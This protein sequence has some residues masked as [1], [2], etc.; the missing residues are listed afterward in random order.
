[1][2]RTVGTGMTVSLL[3]KSESLTTVNESFC[4]VN[5]NIRDRR[6]SRCGQGK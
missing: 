3:M 4:Q 6:L 5:N 1:M 2:E